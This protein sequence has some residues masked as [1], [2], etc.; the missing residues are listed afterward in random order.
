MNKYLLT[1]LLYKQNPTKHSTLSI[2]LVFPLLSFSLHTNQKSLCFSLHLR[3]SKKFCNSAVYEP[4]FKPSALRQKVFFN[5]FFY[6]LYIG[7]KLIKITANYYSHEN[8]RTQKITAHCLLRWWWNGVHVLAEL[9]GM[10][11][12]ALA[13]ATA[14]ML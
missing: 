1:Y 6:C 5:Y 10:L 4:K 8:T 2:L 12:L 13:T 9:R 3:V 7:A 11:V 14:Y